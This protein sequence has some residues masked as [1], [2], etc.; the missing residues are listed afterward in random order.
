MEYLDE[1][2]AAKVIND[3]IEREMSEYKKVAEKEI[4]AGNIAPEAKAAFSRKP[5]YSN[6]GM[7]FKNRPVLR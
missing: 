4:A 5:Y 3:Y 1:K 6:G 7:N 2:G